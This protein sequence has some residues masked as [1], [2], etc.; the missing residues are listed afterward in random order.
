[1]IQISLPDQVV[2]R[3]Q[4][5]ADREGSVLTDVLA[6]AVEQ[7][8]ARVAP[9]TDPS[10]AAD[11]IVS[12]TARQNTQP[13]IPHWLEQRRNIEIEQRIYEKQHQQILTEYRGKYIAMYHGKIVDS[14]IDGA[15]LSQRIRA[16]Y[17]NATV[18]ITPV[19]EEPM[20]TITVRGPRLEQKIER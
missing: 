13:E 12:V 19:L 10:V 5:V 18:L 11:V 1:M 15:S 2:D 7:Y 20:Q 4:A 17:G 3:L 9:N 6:E 8:I 16:C 14:D